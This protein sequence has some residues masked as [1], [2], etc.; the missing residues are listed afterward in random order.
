VLVVVNF[1]IVALSVF[2][3]IK[4]FEKLQNLRAREP[5]PEPLTAARSC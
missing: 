5:E 2:I 1:L 3:M 4:T